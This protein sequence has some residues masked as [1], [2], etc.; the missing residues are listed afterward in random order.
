MLLLLLLLLKYYPEEQNV[1]CLPLKRKWKMFPN[2]FEQWFKRRTWLEEQALVYT[3]WT[4]NARILNMP[5]YTEIYSNV[6]KYSSINV[7]KNVTENMPEYAWN[8]TCLN[9][10]VLNIPESA[11]IRFRLE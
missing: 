5:E 10:P 11:Y 9:Q 2:K 6:G 8:I 1:K 3:I 4:G 7:T